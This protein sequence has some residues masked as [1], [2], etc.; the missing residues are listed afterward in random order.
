MTGNDLLVYWSTRIALVEFETWVALSFL[1]IPLFMVWALWRA[2]KADGSIFK[3]V[4][5]VTGDTGRGSA[6]ALGYT[7]LVVVCAW[8]VW[9]LIVLDRLTEW[10]MTLI[11]G[12]FVLGTLGARGAQLMA[13]TKGAPEPPAGA[14]DDPVD[15]LPPGPNL[16]GRK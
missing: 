2:D 13:R 3:L 8:G 9:A 1:P 12:G 10:Y 15:P 6:F 14:G 16:E 4:H 7:V 5:F 11:I